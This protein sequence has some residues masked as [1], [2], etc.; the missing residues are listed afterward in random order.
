M[1]R[2]ERRLRCDALDR[3]EAALRQRYRANKRVLD[4]LDKVKDLI[5]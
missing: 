1:A 3:D 2:A 5:S 4:T